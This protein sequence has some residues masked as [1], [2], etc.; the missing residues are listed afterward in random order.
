MRR[1]GVLAG[2]TLAVAVAVGAARAGDLDGVWVVGTTPSFPGVRMFEIHAGPSPSG[3]LTTD[4]YGAMPMRNLRI[5]GDVA[6][7]EIDNGN[8]RLQAHTWTATRQGDGVRLVGDIWYQHVDASAHAGS[9][10]ERHALAFTLQPPPMVLRALSSNGLARTPPMGWSSWNKFATRIDDVAVRQIAD[11]MVASGLR[12]AGYVYVNIDDGW[13]GAR[14]AN[15]VLQPNAKFPDMAGLARYV[16]ARGL[17]LGLYSSPGPKSCAGYVGSYGHVVQ[18]ARTW[19]GW[20][21]DYIKYD[22]CSGEGFYRSPTEIRATYQEMGAALQA[23]G[24]P[25]VFSLCEYG[26]ADVGSWGRLVAGNLWRTSGD[27]K[28]SYDSMAAIG[29]DKGGKPEDAGPGGWNDLDMLEVGNG[30]MTADEYRTHL[31]LWAMQ[32]APLM[33]GN[34]LRTMTPE[35]VALLT[36]KT[37]LAIDQ[38]PLGRQGRRLFKRGD[39]EVWTRPLADGAMAVAVFNRAA[40]PLDAE[41]SWEELGVAAPARL[42]GAWTAAPVER[43]ASGFKASVPTHGVVLLR[44]G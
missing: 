39:L 18:D 11:A 30:G 23:T 2:V 12:D 41:L 43:S 26:R 15:G 22:L 40:Q 5:T 33:T 4:W 8:P 37:M 1:Y 21:V 42:T 13:Q 28:D 19:A 34:D 14:D 7:F 24:R 20:G 9:E 32:A 25:I 3:T 36:D 29:F 10:T 31:S 17:K 44:A 6:S 16:H 27:I 38:D 35:T